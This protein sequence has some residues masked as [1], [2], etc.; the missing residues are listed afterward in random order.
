L[1]KKCPKVFLT[2][3][4]IRI[5]GAWTGTD[6]MILET[7]SPEKNCEKIGVFDLNTLHYIIAF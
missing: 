4:A 2:I 7:Y 6:V 3:T 1:A 5:I